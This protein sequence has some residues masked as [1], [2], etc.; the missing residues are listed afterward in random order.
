MDHRYDDQQTSLFPS[1]TR[2]LIAGLLIEV[3]PGEDL[4]SRITR[5]VLGKVSM[6][7]RC[8]SECFDHFQNK[9][10]IHSGGKQ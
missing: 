10:R 7:A 2:L 4:S 3:N 9:I 6:V 8:S 1:I 5:S